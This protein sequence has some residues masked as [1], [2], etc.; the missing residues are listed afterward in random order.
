MSTYSIC[1]HKENKKS[2]KKVSYLE[3]MSES[4][5]LLLRIHSAQL[6]AGGC[7]FRSI[8]ISC[9]LFLKSF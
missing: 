3:L 5:G 8:V 4:T 2:Y 1:F 7:N 9:L 6:S